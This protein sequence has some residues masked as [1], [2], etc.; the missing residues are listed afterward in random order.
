MKKIYLNLLFF[1]IIYCFNIQ[2]LFSERSNEGDLIIQGDEVFIIENEEFTQSGGNIIINDNG[3]LII[4]NSTFNFILNY[5]E[6]FQLSLYDS[7]KLEILN[8]KV[9]SHFCF[10]IG[11]NDNSEVLI[12]SS[13]V[14][15]TFISVRRNGKLSV[16]DNSHVHNVLIGESPLSLGEITEVKF[17]NSSIHEVGFWLHEDWYCEFSNLNND[18]VANFEVIYGINSTAPFNVRFENTYVFVFDMAVLNN[19]KFTLL[20]SNIFTVGFCGNEGQEVYIENSSINCLVI[21]GDYIS[22]EFNGLRSGY[23]IIL[24]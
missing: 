13:K 1:V 22:L 6:E 18:S 11:I 12:E 16:L 4:G 14:E 9:N 17:E 8:S 5:H 24:T 3:K 7:A 15:V 21:F 20:N 19:A 10:M 23:L 2:I